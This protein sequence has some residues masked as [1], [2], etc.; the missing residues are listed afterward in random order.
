MI[1]ITFFLFCRNWL[2]Y[3][4]GGS[5]FEIR[6]GYDAYKLD[7]NAH[8]C[9]YLSTWFSKDKFI[10]AYTKIIDPMNGNKMWPKTPY[11]KPLPP[12]ERRM[13]SKPTIKTKRHETEN[14]SKYPTVSN[15]GRPKT[16]RKLFTNWS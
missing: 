7:L 8:Y 4:A 5:V 13:P 14:K 10:A 12:K 11:E 15:V 3:L 2:V 16:C 6:N 1:I 9:H